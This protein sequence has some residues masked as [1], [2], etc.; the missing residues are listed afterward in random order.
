MTAIIVTQMSVG[1]S[2]KATFDYLAGTLGGAI[3][4]AL[5][6][7]LFR[8]PAKSRFSLFLRLPWPPGLAAAINPTFRVFAPITAAIVLLV[9]ELPM[10]ARWLRHSTACSR[11]D[12][13]PHRISRFVPAATVERL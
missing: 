4:G 3:Y 11:S 8:I 6:R 9:P 7:S 2:L 10:R 5:S 12:S 1:Q 13:G